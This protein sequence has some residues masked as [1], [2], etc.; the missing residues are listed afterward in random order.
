LTFDLPKEPVRNFTGGNGIL[1]T[2]SGLGVLEHLAIVPVGGNG[3]YNVYVDNF[4]V[5]SPRT[6][7]FG[8]ASSSTPGASVNPTTGVFTWPTQD[9]NAGTT[10]AFAVYVT[11][12]GTPASKATNSF[13]IAVAP[14]PTVQVA[15][16]TATNLTLGWSAVPGTTYRVQFKTDLDDAA[17]VDVTPD[18][19][20]TGGTV[21][22][23]EGFTAPQRFYRVLAIGD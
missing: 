9:A 3:V 11:D 13:A 6:L 5:I 23:S 20:A 7:S 2:A 4:V 22:F 10:N 15:S 17:W 21:T 12:N 8:L 16:V 1:S 18:I 14:R 19:L